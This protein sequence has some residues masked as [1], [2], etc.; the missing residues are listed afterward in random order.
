MS[1][2]ATSRLPAAPTVMPFVA[3][4]L[5]IAIATGLAVSA[6]THMA[7]GPWLQ[8][9]GLTGVVAAAAAARASEK[10]ARL[11]LET[12]A[13][14]LILGTVILDRTFAHLAVS[15]GP[16]P[17]YVTDYALALLLIISGLAPGLNPTLVSATRTSARYF[18]AF[19]VWGSALLVL[20]LLTH[21]GAAALRE[22]AIFYYALF[23]IVGF[24]L[25]RA[26]IPVRRLIV[27]Y[28][29][30]CVVLDL[31]ALDATYRGLGQPVG[32]GLTRAITGQASLYLAIAAFVAASRMGTAAPRWPAIAIFTGAMLGVFLGQQRTVWVEFPIITAV[33]IVLAGTYRWSL[34]ALVGS[35]MIG[36]LLIL[37]VTTTNSIVHSRPALVPGTST[38]SPPAS[39]GP[40]AS[41]V[42]SPLPGVTPR[43]NP[44]GQLSDSANRLATGLASPASDPTVAWRI[45][46]WKEAL[47]HVEH[48]PIW[49]DGLGR[50]F[51]WTAA[52]RLVTNYPHNTF[53]TVALKSGIPGL[54]LLLVPLAVLYWRSAR[55]AL[56][57]HGTPGGRALSGYLA[58]S[59]ALSLYGTFNLLL[60]SPYLAWPFWAFAGMLLAYVHQKAPE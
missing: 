44:S 8:I 42:E 45:A 49:A 57:T 36:A 27:V 12:V 19:L 24:V 1:T 22:Y 40:T 21:R 4:G 59:L 56:A 43:S 41:P 37:A 15:V 25:I 58:A 7:S 10:A 2:V 35:F 52:G 48:N 34:P 6:V 14:A 11:A 54:L 17:L 28:L 20:A 53:I 31:L 50:Q 38:A 32:Y 30:A 13:A 47:R 3:A 26:Q 29:V 16:L 60:E 5:A 33:A 9:V 23:L 18:G 39:P 55:R 51:T 46:G